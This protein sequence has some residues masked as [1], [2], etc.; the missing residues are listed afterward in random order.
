MTAILELR[1]AFLLPVSALPIH[2]F[3]ASVGSAYTHLKDEAR[4]GW[5]VLC[6]D[7]TGVLK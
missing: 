5:R 4:V 3:Y 7:G 6:K 1:A 2:E